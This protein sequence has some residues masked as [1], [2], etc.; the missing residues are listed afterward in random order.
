MLTEG[1]SDIIFLP[2]EDFIKLTLRCFEANILELDSLESFFDTPARLLVISKGFIEES[3]FSFDFSLINFEC[4]SLFFTEDTSIA[5][6][7]DKDCLCDVSLDFNDW[8]TG[9]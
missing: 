3:D 8:L 5:D 6:P 7:K 1:A 4:F 9:T 2:T